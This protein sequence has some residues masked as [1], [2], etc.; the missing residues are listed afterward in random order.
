MS[1]YHFLFLL[2]SKGAIWPFFF[3]FSGFVVVYFRLFVHFSIFL[4]GECGLAVVGAEP[5]KG[6]LFVIPKCPVEIQEPVG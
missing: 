5:E 4:V 3:P 6:S 2:F 1:T